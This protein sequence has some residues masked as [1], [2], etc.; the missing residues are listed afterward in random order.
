[1]PTSDHTASV[2]FKK[3]SGKVAVALFYYIKRGQ[4]GGWYYFFPTDSHITGM[5]A[6]EF[7]KLM[8]EEYNYSHNFTE[9]QP[10]T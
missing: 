8:A 6:F 9:T 7:H 5:R 4:S 3:S 10:K 2:M 1:M